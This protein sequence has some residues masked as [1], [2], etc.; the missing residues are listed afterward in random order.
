MGHSRGHHLSLS[1][2]PNILRGISS[3]DLR[4]SN[5]LCAARP[6]SESAAFVGRMRY[7]GVFARLIELPQPVGS[8]HWALVVPLQRPIIH[9]EDTNI[10]TSV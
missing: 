1:L 7:R 6:S 8:I 10:D 9:P 3:A 5:L 2:G 4:P